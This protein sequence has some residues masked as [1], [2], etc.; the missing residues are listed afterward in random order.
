MYRSY[1][2]SPAR[3]VN[4]CQSVLLRTHTR[5]QRAV[6]MTPV[7]WTYKVKPQ[8]IVL[9]KYKQGGGRLSTFYT[10]SHKQ[11][12]IIKLISHQKVIIDL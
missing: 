2:D 12:F 7:S 4:L 11:I 5:S 9:Q 8:T 6:E 3:I 10:Y 1:G